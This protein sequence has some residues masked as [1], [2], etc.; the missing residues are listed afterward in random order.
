MSPP[1]FRWDVWAGNNNPRVFRWV[2]SAGAGKS[3]ADSVLVL[4]IT[5]PGGA[6][7]LRSDED[8]Q[9]V[10]W[11]QD[12]PNEVG[13]YSVQFTLAQTRD[14]PLL[15]PMIFE[16]ERWLDGEQETLLRGEIVAQTGNNVDA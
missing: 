3:L 12:D 16:I 2:N 14:F 1:F 6:L 10:I 11:D 9:P 15:V 8:G 13:M 4:T 5:W 7:T